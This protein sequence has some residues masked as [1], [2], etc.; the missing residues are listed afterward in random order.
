VL[1]YI[2]RRIALSVPVLV[3]ASFVA[4]V[5][6]RLAFDPTAKFRNLRD[7]E[8]FLRAQKRYGLNQPV[9]L[10]WLKWIGRVFQGD[11]GV[12]TRTGSPVWPDVVRSLGFT[13]QLILWGVLLALAISVAIGVFS[14]TRQY[15]IGDYVFTGLSYVGVAMPPF[16]FGLLLIQVFGIYAKEHWGFQLFFVGLHSTDKS[17]INLDYIK[18]LILPV[19]TLAVQLVAQWSRFERAALLDVLSSEYV[20]TAQAKGLSRRR[21]I[22]GH[23][24][25][26]SLTPLVTDVATQAGTLFGGLVITET[27]FSIPGMGR[28]TLLSIQTGDVYAVVTAM[29]VAGAFVIIFNLLSDLIYGLLDPRVRLA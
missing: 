20:R 15:S 12:S 26:N 16:W 22:W 18:H 3:L 23:A 24:F 2:S 14:A 9:P 11:F 5:A 13:V 8:T 4:F 19:C 1:A 6:V 29:F 21:V 27:I 17:G 10:Q 28:Y 7:P 25:R